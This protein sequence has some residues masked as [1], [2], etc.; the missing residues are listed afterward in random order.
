MNKVDNIM[1]Y[2]PSQKKLKYPNKYNNLKELQDEERRYDRKI[3]VHK[4]K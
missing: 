3:R 1:V 4:N 2:P